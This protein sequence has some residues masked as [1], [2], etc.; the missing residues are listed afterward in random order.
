MRLALALSLCLA[1][2]AHAGVNKAL[3]THILPGFARFAER[4]AR[5]SDA[6]TED[7]RAANLHPDFHAAFDAWMTVGDLRLGPSETGALSVAFW[8]DPRGFTQRTLTRLIAE[9]DPIAHAPEDYPEVSIAAR[10]VFALEILLFDPA[11]MTYEEGSYT[12]ALV[13]TIATD[14]E[15]Q[16]RAL[17]SA[18]N[19]DFA[20]LLRKA[21]APGNAA[22]LSGDEALRALYTQVLSAL[23]LTANK[24]L[25]LPMGTF[26]RPRPAL[27]EARRSGRSL[28]QVRLA[29][30]AAHGLATALA[31]WDLPQ[32]DAALARVEAAADTIDDPAFQDITDP[33]ARLRL[34]VLQQ[35]VEG[36]HDAIAA[37]IGTRLGIAPGFNAQ[38]GD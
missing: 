18:W 8:P 27:A 28:R 31:D 4:A 34:E 26:E 9:E 1:L 20:P 16:A 29:A 35:A 24:R 30:G 10:G 5:L 37:E 13:T 12:C 14:L 33:Q 6:A 7:C 22:Y 11:F 38:D 2:P 19:D 17:S 36:L 15:A 3:D 21:G 32:S 23:E 25:G